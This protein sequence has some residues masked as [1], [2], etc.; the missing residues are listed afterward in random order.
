MLQSTA[1][2]CVP[3]PNR[4]AELALNR[5]RRIVIDRKLNRSL[6]AARS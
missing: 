3:L 1:I 5:V 6:V 4:E 2:V